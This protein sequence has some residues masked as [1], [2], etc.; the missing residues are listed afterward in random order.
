MPQSSL[1]TR[2]IRSLLLLLNLGAVVWLLLCLMA[3]YLQPQGKVSLISLFS[4]STFFALLTHIGFIVFWLFFSAKKWRCLLSLAAI[5]ICWPVVKP[6]FGINY[7]GNNN[8]SAE[9]QRLKIMTW[10]VHLFDLGEWTK[11]KSSKERIIRLIKEENPD[12]LC[13]QEFYRDNDED[14][15][16]YTQLLQQQGY[17]YAKFSQE[18]SIRKNFITSKAGKKERINI[19]HAIFSKY[20]LKNERQFALDKSNYNMLSVNVVVQE[21]RIFSLNVIHLTSVAFGN[22]EMGYIEDVKSSSPDADREAKSKFLL[23]KLRRAIEKRAK[24]VNEIDSLKRRMEYPIIVC[25]DF[26]DVPGSYAYRK[27]KGD[28]AD[29]FVAKG[30]GLGRTYLKIFPTLRIDYI[31]YDDKV[32]KAEGYDRPKVG[33]S[34]HFPVIATFS[35]RK[36]ETDTL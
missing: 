2:I 5:A 29:A 17:P 19:G 1:F 11:D 31:L 10:N 36:Q 27:V 8:T 6:V 15:E 25:G 12:I 34:D 20:P 16:P 33:L 30:T 13:L 7:F 22:R 35:Y 9:E 21:D 3:A 18:H 4:F 14:Q 28:L 32:L 24:L 23:A 26:N